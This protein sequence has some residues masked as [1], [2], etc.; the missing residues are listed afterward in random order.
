VTGQSPG[1]GVGDGVPVGVGLAVGVGVGGGPVTTG[2]KTCE[3]HFEP[4]VTPGHAV[5]ES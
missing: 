5:C 3:S 4:S 1:V 2:I